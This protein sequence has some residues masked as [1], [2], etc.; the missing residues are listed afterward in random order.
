M[1]EPT[2]H[3]A[4]RNRAASLTSRLFNP[5]LYLRGLSR[6]LLPG[7]AIGVPLMLLSVIM[8]LRADDPCLSELSLPVMLTEWAVPL[9][10]LSAF[11]FLRSRRES[12]VTFAA[13]VTRTC[14]FVSTCLSVLTV[15]LMLVTAVFVCTVLPVMGSLYV[16]PGTA[17]EYVVGVGV[18]GY[19]R[20]TLYAFCRGCCL[21]GVA[22][23]AV[24]LS[25]TIGHALFL[26]LLFILT[27]PCIDEAVCALMG[28][29]PFVSETALNVWLDLREWLPMAD[30]AA[31]YVW[32]PSTLTGGRI[33][34]PLLYAAVLLLIGWLL[35]CRR[36]AENAGE[37][38]AGRRVLLL[39]VCLSAA[40]ETALAFALPGA[41]IWPAAGAAAVYC[42]YL[43]LTTRRLS[44]LWRYLPYAAAAA[45]VT[46]LLFVGVLHTTELIVFR[47]PIDADQVENVVVDPNVLV[48]HGMI[49]GFEPAEQDP[50]LIREAVALIEKDK[51]SRRPGCGFYETGL[52]GETENSYIFLTMRDGDVRYYK[53][54]A[55][56]DDMAAFAADYGMT[57]YRLYRD[58]LITLPEQGVTE[59][60][61][62]YRSVMNGFPD[63]CEIKIDTRVEP[64]FR[65]EYEALDEDTKRRL[66]VGLP[67]GVTASG[68]LIAGDVLLP[69]A[70][71]EGLRDM[72]I[73]LLYPAPDGKSKE[74]CTL[75]FRIDP[76]LM[77]E[78]YAAI[79]ERNPKTADFMAGKCAAGAFKL[80]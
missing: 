68:Q 24:V 12:D 20:T 69:S 7:L 45:V 39:A 72:Y 50:D 49:G 22:V 17:P 11:S 32:K 56:K 76:E 16:S 4:G 65:Q 8:A 71:D 51:A 23:I 52:T 55:K 41:E 3:R 79:C 25:G 2:A 58:S 13:P 40:T 21:G 33:A 18:T 27:G 73:R 63:L 6:L 29:A 5:G 60:K 37:P 26:L 47:T 1:S 31:G 43:L 10:V 75:C 46:V 61:I 74:T 14:L 70:G 77:P 80:K 78:T 28:N 64:V 44:S 19:I 59:V 66:A 34:L 48:R 15:H 67:G 53:F 35:F 9:L 38:A 54:A 57:A 42:V 62:G 36:K 30:F